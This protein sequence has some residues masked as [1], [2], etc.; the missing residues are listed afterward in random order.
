[1]SKKND[2]LYQNGNNNQPKPP[3]PPQPHS[4][5]ILVGR[6]GTGAPP[7]LLLSTDS[8]FSSAWQRKRKDET[9]EV[10]HDHDTALAAQDENINPPP[11]PPA[12]ALIDPGW[13][14]QR[15]ERV[16]EALQEQ[17][18]VRD[19]KRQVLDMKQ[20]LIRT[21][22]GLRDAEELRTIQANLG[23]FVQHLNNLVEE[24]VTAKTEVATLQQQLADAWIKVRGLEALWSVNQTEQQSL[25]EELRREKAAH[26]AT[27][28]K[29]V[30]LKKYGFDA[31]TNDFT[32]PSVLGVNP[33]PDQDTE[34]AESLREQLRSLR[35]VESHNNREI[36]ELEVM[37]NNETQRSGELEK[38]R[39]DAN[40]IIRA[41]QRQLRQQNNDQL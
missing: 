28:H 17:D 23:M 2:L 41:L 8:T 11:P 34:H 16:H 31:E 13:F 21:Y 36:H 6:A 20:Q 12:A 29:F 9:L 22:G 24:S 18:F 26:R 5:G 39:D 32:D 3:H 19:M 40:K 30:L 1:M 4:V 14:P 38:Q 25:Q 33:Q 27:Q 10:K 7:K 35:V 37:L 15:D